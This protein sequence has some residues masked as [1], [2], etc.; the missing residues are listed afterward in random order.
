MRWGILL[1]Q[2]VI[3]NFSFVSAVAASSIEWVP[4]GSAENPA[5]SQVMSDGTTGY[6]SV[7][8]VYE[9]ARYETT[10]AQYAEFLNG[11]AKSDPNGL[12]NSN[13]ESDT[14]GGIIR[15]GSS[16]N[17]SYAL[18]PGMQNLPVNWVSFWDG[19]RFANW[20]NNGGGNAST[21]SGSYL[22]TAQAI[23]ENSVTRAPGATIVL[24]TEDEW[25]KA[26]YFN[27]TTGT[28]FDFPAG[29]DVQTACA[30]PGSPNSA[31]CLRPEFSS[32]H[33]GQFYAV[34]SYP[35]SASP[36]GTSDADRNYKLRLPHHR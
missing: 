10:N 4:V 19:L 28:Y 8:H 11:A 30:D 17:Y 34:G 29:S 12:F 2:L 3:F 33:Q 16:G 26:A 22:L 25:Y 31:N 18:K 15:T 24:P 1:L 14:R 13:M 9:I 36:Y 6:G 35:N 7:S 20:H 23:S 5:D 27:P 32:G 21:D